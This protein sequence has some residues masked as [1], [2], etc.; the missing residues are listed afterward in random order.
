MISAV[1]GIGISAI[2]GVP[3]VDNIPSTGVFPV[4][5]FCCCR[6]ALMFQ[7]SVVLLVSPAAVFVS[8]ILT[9]S[10]ISALLTFLLLLISLLLLS[11]LLLLLFPSF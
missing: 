10:K 2:A 4:L 9:R 5:G 8:E 7:S 6:H 3:T 11:F 1:V